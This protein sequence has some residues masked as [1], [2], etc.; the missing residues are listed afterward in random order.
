VIIDALSELSPEAKM[1]Q[2]IDACLFSDELD[3][4]WTGSASEL[5]QALTSNMSMGYEAKKLFAFNTACGVY[6][7]RLAKKAPQRFTK[8]HGNDGNTWV[9]FAPQV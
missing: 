8:K 2:I 7:A 1:E 5:E 9:I 6:L 3:R 4:S